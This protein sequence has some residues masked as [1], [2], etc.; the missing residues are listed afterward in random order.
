MISV[1]SK[2]NSLGNY[3]VIKTIP[4][5]RQKGL[6]LNVTSVDSF[7]SQKNKGWKLY[8][9]FCRHF[10]VNDI[11]RHLNLTISKGGLSNLDA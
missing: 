9:E 8:T 11:A 2:E 7:S 10:F 4:I 5:T 1:I 6:I 3:E